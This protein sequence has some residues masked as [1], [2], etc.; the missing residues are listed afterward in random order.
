MANSL[1][2]YAAAFLLLVSMMIPAC[3]RAED[4]Y[5][6]RFA[7]GLQS[8][9]VQAC[10][11]GKAPARL[12]RYHNAKRYTRWVRWA[13]GTISSRDN[14]SRL[15]LPALPDNACIDW[16]VDLAEALDE[17]DYRLAMQRGDA[18]LSN[19]ALWFWRDNER[20]A[21]QVEVEMPA[22]WSFSAPWKSL[23]S[24]GSRQVYRVEATPASWT[25]R[26]AVGKFPLHTVAVQGG[27]LRL[28]ML[29]PLDPEQLV[30]FTEWIRT[31]ANSVASVFG[32]FP[33]DEPQVLL[34]ASGKQRS[35]VPWA[36]VMR[37][38]GIAA[39]LFVDEQR[40]LEEL[41]DDWTATHEL[42]H[43]LLPYVASSDRWLSEGLA[44]YYQNVLRARDGRL[45][46]RAAWARLHGG[47]ERGMAATRGGSLAHA[48]RSG[49]SAVMRVYWSGAAIM[50]EADVRLRAL[51]DGEQSLDTALASL[52]SCCFDAGQSWR[53]RELFGQLDQITGYT[54]FSDLYAE[55]VPNTEFPDVTETYEQLGLV[56]GYRSM[57]IEP[58]APWGRIRYFIMNDK[59]DGASPSD[60]LSGGGS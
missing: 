16:E 32:D 8:V 33:R 52:N 20:R 11:E 53:A 39:E 54:V 40:S 2:H 19:G 1:F 23:S 27:Q 7:E 31:S 34:I 12:Y 13:G 55:H 26:I 43:M 46:E 36:H 48:T 25:F 4:H 28:A 15:K 30:R 49:R 18:L 6:V 17:G 3:A 60:A 38:G 50:L 35:A 45:S 58:D 24:E 21:I 47:F 14:S 41:N 9:T 37:G 29:G 44:S 22:G 42:S 57:E 10:F 5:H 56:P 59:P 51:S